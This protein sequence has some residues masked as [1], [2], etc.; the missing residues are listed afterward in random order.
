MALGVKFGQLRHCRVGFRRGDVN[1]LLI[2]MELA[3]TVAH[4]T[5]TFDLDHFDGD[6]LIEEEKNE[7]SK[8]QKKGQAATLSVS[9]VAGSQPRRQP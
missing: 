7:M 5:E 4:P 1:R 8:K 9:A 2:S 6:G 3:I